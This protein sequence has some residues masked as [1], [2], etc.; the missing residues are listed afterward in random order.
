MILLSFVYLC[1]DIEIDWEVYMEEVEGVIN[2]IYD[3]INLRGGI[4]FLV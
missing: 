2:G 4:G 1:L 3:Y